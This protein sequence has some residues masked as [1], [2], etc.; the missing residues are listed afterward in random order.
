MYIGGENTK[1]KKTTRMI[2]VVAIAL[3]LTIAFSGVALAAQTS[4]NCIVN[5]GTVRVQTSFRSTTEGD[6]PPY[7]E[8]GYNYNL[9]GLKG[10]SAITHM[11][12]TD[13]DV[14]VENSVGYRPTGYG[15]T[16]MFID[17]EVSTARVA[18]GDNSSVCCDSSAK[19]RVNAN[20]VDYDSVAASG[21]N[22]LLFSVKS[23]GLGGINIQTQEEKLIGDQNGTW[24]QTRSR[25]RLSVNN[26]YYNLSVDYMSEGCE[27]PAMGIPEKDMLCP[28][29]RP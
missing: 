15:L 2:S 4:F 29:M 6:V 5:D 3:V 13:E 10:N 23:T 8:T 24:T 16:R 20:A 14:E 26:G 12:N 25:D 17:E 22:D 11:I 7:D 28:F 27:Y 1:M 18:E 21:N 19:T 9:W